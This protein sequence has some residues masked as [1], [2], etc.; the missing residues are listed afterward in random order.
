MEDGVYTFDHEHY[1]YGALKNDFR[2]KSWRRSSL[3]EENEDEDEEEEEADETD[4]IEDDEYP[5][6]EEA[7][8]ET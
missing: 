7:L 6:E 3:A 8:A 5:E 4:E 2:H 1:P